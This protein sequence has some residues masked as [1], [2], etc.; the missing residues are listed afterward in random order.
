MNGFDAVGFGALNVDWLF[1]VNRI[2]AAEEESFVVDFEESCGGSAANTMV[3]LARLGC[4]AGFV[5]KVAN[6]VE[7]RKLLE[8]FRNERVD[9]EGV[10]FAGLGRTGKVMGFVDERAERALYVDSGV[11]DT[12]EPNEIRADYVSQA[13]FLHL[14]S[15]VGEQGLHTQKEIIA[16]LPENVKVSFDPRILVR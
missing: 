12:L 8:D 3:G 10:A 15:F 7:G 16:R 9:V 5:G 2:A 1:K 13:R 14:T 4:R 11:N 6:D